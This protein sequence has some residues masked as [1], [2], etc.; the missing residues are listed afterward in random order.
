MERTICGC[1]GTELYAVIQI[2]SFI[3]GTEQYRNDEKTLFSLLNKNVYNEKKFFLCSGREA[4][5]AAIN[6]V[7]K[8]M[9]HVNKNCLLPQYTCETVIWPFIQAN[10]KKF[11]CKLTTYRV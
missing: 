10:W 3:E 11:F 2:G 9:P 6:D 1:S 8:N 4:L 5:R 7:E